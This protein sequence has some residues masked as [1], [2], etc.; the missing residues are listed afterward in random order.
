MRL[1]ALAFLAG[2]A[3]L[4]H[5]SQLPD[6][7]LGLGGVAALLALRLVRVPAARA[8]LLLLA[9]ALLGLGHAAWRADSRLADSLPGFLEGADIALVGVVADLP[10]ARSR[11][12]RFTFEVER[13]D[14]PGARVPQRLS[15]AWYPDVTREGRTEVPSLVPGERW[16]L[17]ARLKRIR[18]L[19]N[20]HTFDFEPWALE[21]AL[22][23]SG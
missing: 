8:L 1:F 16:Q 6:P 18:G 23:A 19:S 2:T 5:A 13:V 14:T 20:P 15:L 10:Q 9:G 11:G 3:L 17:T 7:R 12:T 22:G 21:R 4:Q